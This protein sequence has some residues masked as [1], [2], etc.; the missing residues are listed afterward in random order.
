MA[1]T[2]KRWLSLATAAQAERLAKLADTSV[3]SLRHITAGRRNG[4]AETAIR[5]AA[6]SV[7][8]DESPGEIAQPSICPACK[9]CQF[10]RRAP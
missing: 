4:S 2:L 7:Q 10:F 9:N 5:I 6:A 3:K 1:L 8:V